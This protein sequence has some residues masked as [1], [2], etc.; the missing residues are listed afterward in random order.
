AVRLSSG[1]LAIPA[2]AT[3]ISSI[4]PL[5]HQRVAVYDRILAHWPVRFLLADDAGAGKTIMAGLVIRELLSRRLIRRVLIVPPAG[6]VGN[7]YRELSTLFSLTFK[8]VRGL[9]ARDSNPF[10][11]DD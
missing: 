9:D 5:P 2:F 8:K 11:G 4:D 7:W 1:H 3:D 6:L 10:K